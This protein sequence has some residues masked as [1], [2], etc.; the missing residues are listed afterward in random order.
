MGRFDVSMDQT[1]HAED[2]ECMLCTSSAKSVAFVSLAMLKSGST[3]IDHL[4]FSHGL[5]PD[6]AAAFEDQ[7]EEMSPYEEGFHEFFQDG[8]VVRG[9]EN[10]GCCGESL[11][12]QRGIFIYT[13]YRRK[14]DVGIPYRYRVILCNDCRNRL[15]EVGQDLLEE[16][17][18]HSEE[19][20]QENYEW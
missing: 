13:D 10:C 5:G 17:A 9:V 12:K 15:V 3:T 18:A 7:L 19:W 11:G 20:W 14:D 16:S 8:T 2:D 1:S 4:A 6:C